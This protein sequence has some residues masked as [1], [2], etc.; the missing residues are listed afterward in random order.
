[1]KKSQPTFL[2]DMTSTVNFELLPA[3]IGDLQQMGEMEKACFPLDA[4]PLLEQI[5]A[6]ILPGLVRIKAVSDGRMVGFTGGEI[7]RTQGV[8]WIT[9]LAV[10]PQYRRQ[11]IAEALLRACEQEMGMPY[12]KLSVRRSNIQAQA[13]YL[14][15]GYHH[16]DIW[17]G[18]YDGGE[19]ALVMEKRLP[20]FN[21][22]G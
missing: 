14:K 9:T 19:D 16:K 11:G 21:N 4:W 6:L 13:L 18:Y 17:N 8:G 7:K 1:M 22:V 12:V 2:N 20:E 3:T 10:L 5:A 15:C